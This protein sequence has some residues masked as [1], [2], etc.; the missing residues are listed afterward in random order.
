MPE[1]RLYLGAAHRR[2]SEVLGSRLPRG[3]VP[4]MIN[5]CDP[6]KPEWE[7]EFNPGLKAPRRVPKVNR[8][9]REYLELWRDILLDWYGI[10]P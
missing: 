1:V 2:R 4:A 5:F 3:G 9:F 10:R 7:W 6:L 8:D